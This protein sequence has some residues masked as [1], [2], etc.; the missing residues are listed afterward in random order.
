MRSWTRRPGS[1]V[2][3]LAPWPLSLRAA[4]RPA[5]QNRTLRALPPHTLRR[6]RPAPFVIYIFVSNAP[7]GRD[8]RHRVDID[9]NI[10]TMQWRGLRHGRAGAQRSGG[11]GQA[12]QGCG[13]H[14]HLQD[15]T[16]EEEELEKGALSFAPGPPGTE[17]RALLTQWLTPGS[18]Y[19]RGKSF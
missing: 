17:L 12:S 13:G 2:G 8:D 14:L 9:N 4:I 15:H 16:G 19:R 11:R 3:Q 6:D 7:K 18:R 5:W 1:V 10:M